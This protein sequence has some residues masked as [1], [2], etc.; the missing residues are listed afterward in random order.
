MTTESLPDSSTLS[1]QRFWKHAA[2]FTVPP[3]L[4]LGLTWLLLW[5]AWGAASLLIAL[6]VLLLAPWC[7]AA[8]NILSLIAIADRIKTKAGI[9][10]GRLMI[11]PV[12]TALAVALAAGMLTWAAFRPVEWTLVVKNASGKTLNALRLDLDGKLLVLDKSGPLPGGS[13]I[14]LPLQRSAAKGTLYGD[15]DDLTASVPLPL[16]LIEG[17]TALLLATPLTITVTIE[18]NNSSVSTA[19]GQT[20]FSHPPTTTQPTITFTHTHLR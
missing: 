15:M 12:A 7:V 11:G 16:N 17:D 3:A 19:G 18:P 5:R 13:S 14:T 6:G 9:G 8:G 4:A 20:Y 10:W 1:K 2:W